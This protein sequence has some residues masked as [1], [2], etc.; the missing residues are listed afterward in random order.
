LSLEPGTPEFED[1]KKLVGP[2]SKT[3]QQY[4]VVLATLAGSTTVISSTDVSGIAASLKA[5][6]IT[7]SKV[8]RAL[9]ATSQLARVARQ[10]GETG[11]PYDRAEGRHG[12]F[13][14]S[15]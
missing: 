13:A 12:G 8:A 14:V 5:L 3:L 2:V 6:G 15:E 11:K 7:D 1:A 4:M 9:D 10:T